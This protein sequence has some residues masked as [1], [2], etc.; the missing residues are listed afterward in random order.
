MSTLITGGTGF[1][2]RHLVRHLLDTEEE[3]VVVFD[4]G[5]SGSEASTRDLVLVPGDIL[6][7]S[8]VAETVKRWRVQG[9]IHLAYM[10]EAPND[11]TR[12]QIEVNT[13]GATNVL[14]AAR[15]CGISRVVYA[16]SALV[17]PH[18]LTRA[19]H[20]YRENDP[21]S[22]DGVYGACKLF[23]EHLA[24]Q[25]ARLYGLDP[26]GL[27]FTAVFGPGRAERPGLAHDHNVLPELAARGCPVVM[28][29]D[30]QLSDWMYVADAVEV[31]RLVYRAAALR[32]RVFN[33]ASECRH[34]GEITHFLR[35]LLPE[36]D[37][38][39]SESPHVMTSLLRTDRL[40][41][42]LGFEPRYTTEEGLTEY[43]EA[44]RRSR[45]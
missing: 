39:V 12:R 25:Y 21:P 32:D 14:E 23:N 36:A 29:P 22:P 16:S 10:L 30:D 17:Y 2:G 6:D 43:V 13:V 40:R 7:Y 31:I 42:E 24:E 35:S 8:S 9:I 41:N 38:S 18:R 4:A 44:V 3:R 20:R 26:I 1:L 45:V 15:V 37:I 34:V 27:R 33:V 11:D 5:L 19:G 28:P